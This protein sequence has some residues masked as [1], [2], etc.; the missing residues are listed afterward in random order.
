MLA[1]METNT[2]QAQ[3][4]CIYCDEELTH[5]VQLAGDRWESVSGPF[6]P[7]G[8]RHRPVIVVEAIA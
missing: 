3:V 1:G 2:E 5:P 4:R 8:G 6:C 7:D